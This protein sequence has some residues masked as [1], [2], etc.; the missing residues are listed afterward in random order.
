MAQFIMRTMNDVR[1]E[2]KET[3]YPHLIHTGVTTT[4]DL[5]RALQAS[6]TFTTSDVL[7]LLEA[8]SSFIAT[9]TVKGRS[10]RI[11]GLGTFTASLGLVEGKEREEVEGGT[12][13]NAKSVC[14]RSI[15]FR[16]SRNLIA[17]ADACAHLE[18]TKEKQRLAPIEP[19]SA[20]IEAVKDFFVA[21]RYLR[22]GDYIAMTH[23]SRSKA[24]AELRMFCE[25]GI[26]KTEGR[27]THKVYVPQ[28]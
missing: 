27:G 8:L 6:S 18:R 16:P 28:D 24:V 12:R 1:D 5:A 9:E 13:R 3:T 19:Q 20:R 14:V 15:R 11:D 10:V 22:I 2:G 26:L 4:E 17:R 7:G 25:S 21:H 23:L